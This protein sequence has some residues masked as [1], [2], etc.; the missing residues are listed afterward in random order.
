MY[1]DINVLQTVPA[2]NINR[3]ETGSPKTVIYGGVTRARVS[4]QAWK[5]A[6]RQAF[7]QEGK[8]SDWLEGLRTEFGPILLSKEI[9]KQNDGID[10]ETAQQL[11]DSLFDL[12][13]VSV[14]SDHKTKALYMLSQGQLE[15]MVEFAIDHQ[16]ELEDK[17]ASGTKKF[18]DAVKNAFKGANSADLALFG[19]MVANDQALTVDGAAQVAHA[20]STHEIVPEFDYYSAIDDAK[21]SD[22]D[23]GAAMLG[24]IEYNSSTLYRY[25]NVN[26]NELIHNLGDPEIAYKALRYFI[27]DF[28]MSMP[29]G[30]QHSFANK[31]VPQY[32]M[33][34]LRPDTPVNLVSAFED[35]V[36]ATHGYV[37]PSIKKLEDE[38][39]KIEKM[40]D[41]PVANL[42]LTTEKTSFTDGEADSLT[43]LLNK[44]GEAILKEG[45]Q[46]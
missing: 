26:L 25:A 5:R 28:T 22:S 33:V 19:R 44:V 32:I 42:V 14:N 1:I 18:K 45:A 11:A 9:A 38:Y 40:V 6:V 16:D 41:D 43:D 20:I 39:N 37:A 15:R 23:A 17:K 12:A 34:T 29:T 30:K 2:S 27:K 7:S 10:T 35:P 8:D 36:V 24:T 31:T 13:G 4:S 21:D 46:E 3:D